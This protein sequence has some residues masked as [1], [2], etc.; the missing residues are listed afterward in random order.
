MIHKLWEMALNLVFPP[1]CPVCDRPVRLPEH[2][3]CRDCRETLRYIRPPYCLKCGKHIKNAGEEYCFDCA[4]K[5]HFYDRGK[6][7]Y[8]YSG[9]QASVYRFKYQGRQEYAVFYGEE[10]AARLGGWIRG[11]GAQALV[12][13][14]L[15]RQK[16]R[17]R[18]YNQAELLARQIGRHTGIPVR[19][20][21]VERI[22]KTI[23][24][25]ELGDKQRQNNLKKAFKFTGNDV[26]LST[27]II[28]DDIYT[29]GSTIDEIAKVLKQ[30]GIRRVYYIALSIGRGL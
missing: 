9:I 12:P 7:L 26:K 14:P 17:S 27:I 23:P 20:D 4:Q 2:L 30:S 19:T 24:Q 29:T 18:G 22:R 28:I 11:L 16:L 13:A 25:K 5:R 8:E 10:I 3:I 15:H 6:A 21:L 1:R